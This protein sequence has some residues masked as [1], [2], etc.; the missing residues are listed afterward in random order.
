[1][2]YT[3]SRMLKEAISRA[4][5]KAEEEQSQ[6]CFVC[7]KER[8]FTPGT[9]KI[10]RKDTYEFEAEV[11]S[12]VAP[13]DGWVELV[14]RDLE[15][16][17]QADAKAAPICSS[18]AIRKGLKKPEPDPEMIPVPVPTTPDL[19]KLQPPVNSPDF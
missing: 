14:D 15:F 19:T 16:G 3:R 18:C 8:E 12:V 2:D 5:E 17:D 7:D 10:T 11:A 9:I 6:S 1:M 13:K 4:I